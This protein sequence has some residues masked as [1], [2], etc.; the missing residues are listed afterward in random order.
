MLRHRTAKVLVRG[1]LTPTERLQR[2]MA[3]HRRPLHLL[4]AVVGEDAQEL[5]L[6]APIGAQRASPTVRDSALAN[7]APKVASKVREGEQ[8][9]GFISRFQ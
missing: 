3:S 7:G 9:T 8:A 5:V 4:A 2:A 1:S 6:Q